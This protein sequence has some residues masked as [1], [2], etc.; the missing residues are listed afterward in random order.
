LKWKKIF[1]LGLRN[2]VDLYDS[3]EIINLKDKVEKSSN[4]IFVGADFSTI[5]LALK[6][7]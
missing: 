6:I 3:E 5:K 7:K 2:V 1:G 4:I